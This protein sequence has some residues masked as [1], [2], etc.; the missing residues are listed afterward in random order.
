MYQKFQAD[1][2]FTG[3]K[4]LEGNPKCGSMNEGFTPILVVKEDGTIEDI[5]NKE[6]A[7]EDIQIVQGTLTPGFINAHCHL[8]LSH[9]KDMIPPHT[10]LQEFVKQIVS[11]RKV[12]EHVIAEAIQKAEEEMLANG[13]VAVGDICNTLDTLEQKIK[14]RI[15]YYSFVEL[16]DLDPTRSNDKIIAGLAIQN[17]FQE[18][19]IRASLVPHAP[20]SVS[21]NLWKLLSEHFETHTI[22][23]HNQETKDENDF[24]KTKT[25]SFLC[26]YERTKV[27]L[28]FF[29]ATG[30]SSLQSVLPYFK[31]AH[32]SI[33]VHNSFTSVEDIVAVQKDM[34]NSFWCICAN[35]NQ[36]IEQTMPPIELLRSQKT[37][38]VIGTD[39][40]ASNWSLNILD[41]IKTIQQHLPHIPFEELLGWA[42]INGAQA[43]QMDKHL[44]SFEKGKKPGIV[45]IEGLSKE[46]KIELHTISKRII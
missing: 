30:L 22:T 23:M 46:N 40:Y 12:E 29:E 34:P 17:K 26:M 7:G 14:H 5:I 6:D 32:R 1:Q 28:D 36:Y 15:A 4:L 9:M 2:I 10:G 21:F 42:T 45:L 39:S 24:F 13:I 41:E 19:C 3:K 37:N 44:G 20:Y 16:Y 8:E 27:S 31:K 33:L 35:A 38:I 11:L 25:G 43:L 18:N